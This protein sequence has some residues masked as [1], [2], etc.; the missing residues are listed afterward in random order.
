ML[1]FPGLLTSVNSILHFLSFLYVFTDRSQE[2]KQDPSALLTKLW[3]VPA[4]A[5][6]C[7]GPMI[8]QFISRMSIIRSNISKS[9]AEICAGTVALRQNLLASFERQYV[10]LNWDIPCMWV[11][12]S[13]YNIIP[14][15]CWNMLTFGH[16]LKGGQ[17]PCSNRT[18][19]P[20]KQD[21]SQASNPP[22]ILLNVSAIL[23]E[24]LQGTSNLDTRNPTFQNSKQKLSSR[25]APTKISSL[26]TPT[27]T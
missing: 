20:E 8:L 25:F 1:I 21:S 23:K 3:I 26:P 7:W 5:A 12:F 16:A 4:G 27:T 19:G 2:G 9:Q 17:S 22:L 10:N 15:K 24:Q 6:Y 11:C 13:K 18:A 14:K